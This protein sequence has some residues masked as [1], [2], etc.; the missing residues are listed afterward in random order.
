MPK[1]QLSKAAE[2][3]IASI[4]DYTI[5]NFGIDQARKYR[6]GLIDTLTQI[7]HNPALGQVFILPNTVGLKR[8]RYKAHMIFYQETGSGILIVRI[9]GG[10]MD[11][12][13][14]L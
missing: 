1:F 7:A 11:F 2:E 6:N 13:R 4:A 5:F 14:H 12:K 10:M 9:L 3:D 8:F